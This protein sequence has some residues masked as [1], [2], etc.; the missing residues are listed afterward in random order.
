MVTDNYTLCGDHF[1]VY[2]SIESLRCI[3]E[4]KG[5][6]HLYLKKKRE[7]DSTNGTC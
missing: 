3:L 1:M 5:I 7:E 2:A 4:T 6:S